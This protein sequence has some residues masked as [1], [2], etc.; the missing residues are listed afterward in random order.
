MQATLAGAGAVFAGA[1]VGALAR[2]Q[3]ALKLPVVGG[4]ATG[5][6]AAN[7][8]GAWLIGVAFV[9]LARN[10]EVTALVRLAVIT[11]FL[12]GLTTFSTFSIENLNLLMNGRVLTA[13]GHV[14]LHVTGSVLLAWLG[15]MT[16]RLF[17]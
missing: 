16:A 2:W 5:T 10:G 12:G 11:G 14:A 7:W 15:M 13:L 17:V 6:L 3:L 9:A 8:I 4:V 1:G